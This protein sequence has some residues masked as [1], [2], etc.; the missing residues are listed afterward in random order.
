MSCRSNPSKVKSEAELWRRFPNQRLQR[1]AMSEYR[2]K[3]TREGKDA[4]EGRHEEGVRTK[5]EIES[6]EELDY[7]QV[8]TPRGKKF[9][10][11]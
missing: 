4:A 7:R 10:T 2:A 8:K 6:S 9:E 1:S 5:I 3:G 11:G